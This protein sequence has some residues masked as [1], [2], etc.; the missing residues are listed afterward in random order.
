MKVKARVFGTGSCAKKP[1]LR[2]NFLLLKAV[3]FAA[4]STVCVNKP[5]QIV[6]L[7]VKK[8]GGELKQ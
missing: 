5:K 7:K 6:Y 4:F 2:V 1:F 3:V 8:W